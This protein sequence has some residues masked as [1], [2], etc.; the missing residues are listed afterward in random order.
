[1][2]SLSDFL[3]S[4]GVGFAQFLEREAGYECMSVGLIVVGIVAVDPNSRAQVGRDLISFGLGVL[5][6]SMG[7]RR[8]TGAT[9]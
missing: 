4:V 9:Q 1:M 8:P 7:A 2:R 3:T 5:A 6:R